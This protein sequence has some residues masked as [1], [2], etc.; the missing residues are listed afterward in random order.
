MKRF[1]CRRTNRGFALL[2]LMLAFAILAGFTLV[3]MRAHSSAK[4]GGDITT[5]TNNLNTLVSVVRSSF[6]T[7][8]N[9][10]GLTNAA[11]T[12]ASTFPEGMKNPSD[13][14]L[15]RTAWNS[16][17]VDVAPATINSTDDGFT[18]T[19]KAGGMDKGT[20][21]DF[22]NANYKSYISTTV[23]GTAITGAADVA[24]NCADGSVLVFTAT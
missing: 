1:S 17:G 5:A 24:P 4:S 21:I 6:S 11:V 7:Q 20:C 12:E 14:D 8:G 9:Y 19:Y 13:S 16:D 23:D 15:I 22:V 10:T 18:I 2:E 3:V